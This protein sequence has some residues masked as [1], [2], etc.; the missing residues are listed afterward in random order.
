M[1]NIGNM[2]KQAQLL[3]KKMNEAQE[4]LKSIEVEG[5]LYKHPSVAAAAVVAKSDTK[6][7]EPPC[8]FIELGDGFEANEQDLDKHCRNLLAG[9]KIPRH[10]VFCDLP[11]T[12]TGKI[13]KFL[14]RKETEKI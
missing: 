13:Q 8:A 7:G 14:L 5:I 6:W 3:Q 4:K 11:K 12:S 1:T 10:Y 9:F 2:M